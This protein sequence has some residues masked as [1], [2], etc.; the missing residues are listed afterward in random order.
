M[1]TNLAD[2]GD[3][4][5]CFVLGWMLELGW[6]WFCESRVVHETRHYWIHVQLVCE[7]CCQERMCLVLGHRCVLLVERD[8]D[9]PGE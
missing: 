6:I 8:L 1:Y 5:D 7:V 2:Q 3:C 4:V 9:I